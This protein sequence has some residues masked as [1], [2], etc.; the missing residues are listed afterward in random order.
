MIGIPGLAPYRIEAIVQ[1][2]RLHSRHVQ[3]G[4]TRWGQRPELE[5]LHARLSGYGLVD[6][7]VRN[8]LV[9]RRGVADEA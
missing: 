6:E 3:R 8:D 4:S 2:H 5:H 7:P 1:R 9:R